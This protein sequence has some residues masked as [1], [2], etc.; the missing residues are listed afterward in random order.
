MKHTP[1]PWRINTAIRA[2]E[3]DVKD[4]NSSG[5][6][7]PIAKVRGDKRRTAKQAL[8]NARL[9][10]AAPDLLEAAKLGLREAEGWIRD[11]LEGT[12][13]FDAAMKELDPIRAAIA[14]ATGEQQ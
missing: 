11:Q 5:G 4:A 10:A 9:I 6:H 1:G 7:A 3:F 13:M 12:R 8:A 14:K 2:G